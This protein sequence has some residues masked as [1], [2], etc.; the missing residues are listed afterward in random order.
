MAIAQVLY[1]PHFPLLTFLTIHILF[2]YFWNT[3]FLGHPT[4]PIRNLICPFVTCR[5]HHLVG[6]NH[7]Q[8]VDRPLQEWISLKPISG[9]MCCPVLP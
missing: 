5:Y 7:A 1:K 6:C 8:T 9:S 3:Q 2:H 4:F